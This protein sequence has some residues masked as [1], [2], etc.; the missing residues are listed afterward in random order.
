MSRH[1]NTP[2]DFWSLVD[3]KG[4][5]ECWNWKGHIHDSGYG[6]FGMDG[7]QYVH[8]LAYILTHGSIPKRLYILHKCNN[9]SCCNPNHLEAGTQ[10]ENIKQLYREGRNKIKLNNILNLIQKDVDEM[11]RLYVEEKNTLNQLDKIYNI[12]IPSIHAIIK[13]KVWN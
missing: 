7:I 4:E 5:D 3:K 2:E 9:P 6:Q 1:K 13:G 10:K 8:R 12:G 11:R